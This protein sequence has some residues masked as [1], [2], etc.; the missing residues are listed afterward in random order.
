M[1]QTCKRFRDWTKRQENL[2]I[3]MHPDDDDDMPHW[4]KFR[5]RKPM[6]RVFR[7]GLPPLPF[8][9]PLVDPARDTPDSLYRLYVMSESY[10]F[11]CASTSSLCVSVKWRRRWDWQEGIAA[12]T[13]HLY[14]RHRHHHQH[15][16]YHRWSSPPPAPP[17][18]RRGARLY[19]TMRI[20]QIWQSRFKN[21][22]V[23]CPSS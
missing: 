17:P 21:S 9:L 3:Q 12:G 14:G 13:H 11:F 4:D 2:R 7:G 15:H 10:P 20:L 6:T 19:A 5:R 1:K 8:L 23:D 16:H 18:R 22:V